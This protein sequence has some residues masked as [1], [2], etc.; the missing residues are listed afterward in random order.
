MNNNINLSIIVPVYNS[1]KYLN[2]CITSLQNQTL[3]N[4]EIILINDG[5][6]DKSLEICKKYAQNDNRITVINQENSG[7]ATARNVGIGF[8]HGEYITFADSDD[9]LDKDYYEKLVLTAKKHDAEIA[10]ASIIRER[11]NSRKYRILYKDESEYVMAQDK[12]DITKCP[13]MCYVWNK[14]Y[15]K[16]FLNKID[17]RFADGKFCEDVDFV[18]RAVYYSN[19]IVTVPDTFY[20]YRVNQSSTVKTMMKYDNKRADYIDAKANMIRFF[21]EHKLHTKPYNLIKEKHLFKILGL[22]I[23]KIY[24]WET[25]K[26]YLLFGFIPILEEYVYA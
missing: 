20:H 17:L 15:K 3:K 5:S 12:I 14:V 1:E 16:D 26:Q 2:E 25:K 13:N 22:T 23:L 4:I 18:C 11:K 8:A 10:C 21:K 7:Q 6:K 24:I 9:W 19:K